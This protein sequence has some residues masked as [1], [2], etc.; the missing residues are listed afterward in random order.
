MTT[1]NRET[2]RNVAE[3]TQR[4]VPVETSLRRWRDTP[5]T[6]RTLTDV[7]QQEPVRIL[8]S[9]DPHGGSKVLVLN[10]HQVEAA[11]SRVLD[12]T[13]KLHAICIKPDQ[14]APHTGTVNL[15]TRIPG[16]DA[17]INPPDV[18]II[19]VDVHTFCKV[20]DLHMDARGEGSL[21]QQALP[22]DRPGYLDPQPDRDQQQWVADCLEQEL[23]IDHEDRKLVDCEETVHVHGRA[24]KEIITASA[25]CGKKIC[26]PSPEERTLKKDNNCFDQKMSEQALPSSAQG[27]LHRQFGPHTVH[28]AHVLAEP[29]N[30]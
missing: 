27:A 8:A 17:M 11:R 10:G 15:F 7:E 1:R 24:C 25:V 2:P 16:Q 18:K 13:A 4:C 20:T 14:Q 5:E 26:V 28:M 19:I 29:S 23:T 21:G 30:H 22:P 12:H 3:E 6:I 9:G